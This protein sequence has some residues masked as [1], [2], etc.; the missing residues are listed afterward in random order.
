MLINMLTVYEMINVH[1]AVSMVTFL[2]DC[3]IADIVLH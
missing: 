2:I 3:V 1:H